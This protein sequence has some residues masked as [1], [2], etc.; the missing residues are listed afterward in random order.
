[1]SE[2]EEML[3][4]SQVARMCGVTSE[5]VRHWIRQGRF[6]GSWRGLGVTSPYHIPRSEVE[7]F[8][9]QKLQQRGSEDF[10]P[11]IEDDKEAK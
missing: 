9:A 5:T 4:T 7:T 8:I 2:N 6:P 11:T 1:M 10:K 3:S